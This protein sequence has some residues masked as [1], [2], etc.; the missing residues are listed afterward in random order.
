[1]SLAPLMAATLAWSL[2]SERIGVLGGLAITVALGGLVVKSRSAA[3]GIAGR[4]SARRGFAAPLWTYLV[5][6]E[7]TT[8]AVVIGGAH[9][10]CDGRVGLRRGRV[11]RRCP[12]GLNSE[13]G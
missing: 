6:N 2:L 12:A 13:R 9:T 7:I 8:P 5:F 11:T 4:R 1:M 10:H 3:F